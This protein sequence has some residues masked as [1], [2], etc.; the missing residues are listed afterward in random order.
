ML[1]NTDSVS[2]APIKKVDDPTLPKGEEKQ[3]ELV[4]RDILY[5]HIEYIKII[6]EMY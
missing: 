6:M 2:E 4:E 1:T 5:L 3:L